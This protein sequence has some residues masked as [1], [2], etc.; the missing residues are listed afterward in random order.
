MPW[1]F[2]VITGK[3]EPRT[4][5]REVLRNL[6]PCDLT[7]EF[8]N[9]KG[10]T[11]KVNGDIDAWTVT[12]CNFLKSELTAAQQ[13]GFNERCQSMDGVTIRMEDGPR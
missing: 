8:V 5:H 2:T 12:G 10:G 4:H 9:M 11:V 6:L 1:T 7:S 3:S 13:G